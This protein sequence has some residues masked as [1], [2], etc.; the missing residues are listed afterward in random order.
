VNSYDGFYLILVNSVDL[1][2]SAHQ[3][4]ICATS[5]HDVPDQ[6][7]LA[8]ISSKDRDLF[9]RVAQE[10]HVHKDS[11]NVLGLGQ[12]LIEVRVR[13]RLSNALKKIL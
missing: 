6:V 4:I 11:H 5:I 10:T 3:R 1:A 8:I 2:R 9:G 13:F 12:V 7:L